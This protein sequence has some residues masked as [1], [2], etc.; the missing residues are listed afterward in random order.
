[1]FKALTPTAGV[2]ATLPLLRLSIAV[3]ML[4]WSV[5]KL[6]KPEGYVKIFQYFYGLSFDI[7]TVYAIGIVQTAIVIAFAIGLFRTTTY[8]LM[9]LMNAI[10]LVVS[11]PQI[12]D[13]YGGQTNHL[14]AASVPVLAACVVLFLLREQDNKLILRFGA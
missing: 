1:M 14:F 2:A 3:F 10:T 6:V 4:V 12:L 7:G 13:P 11:L 5:E 8:G 9:V